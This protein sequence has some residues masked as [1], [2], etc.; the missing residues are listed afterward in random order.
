MRVIPFSI[1]KD[2]SEAFR[3]QI[4]EM[5]RLYD[6]LHQHPEIQLT[7]ILESEGTLL[8]GDYIGRFEP[9]DVFVLGSN[10]P[11]VFRNDPAYGK[12]SRHAKAISLFFDES[13]L[14]EAFWNLPEISSLKYFIRNSAGGFRLVGKQ[15]EI[16]TNLLSQLIAE[17][18]LQR[19]IIFLKILSCF[20][21]K[22]ALIALSGSSLNK[23]LKSYDGNR[24]NL[25]LKFTFQEFHRPIELTE[26]AR[27]A[28]LTPQ[29]FCKYFKTR[30]RK[31]YVQFLNEIRIQHAVRLLNNDAASIASIAYQSGF[32]NLSHFNRTF[33]AVMQMPP[34]DYQ[35]QSVFGINEM[36][37]PFTAS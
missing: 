32:L 23:N 30:T 12:K 27:L 31:T 2:T 36:G 26:I 24:L 37:M 4:D 19:L 25:V 14:G 17:K 13:T 20:E 3:V 18:G 1:P 11:H 7:C 29:A 22:K 16:V 35:K 33:K 9:G 15:K 21:K 34:R 10:Q 6:H 8:A 5:P 28:N